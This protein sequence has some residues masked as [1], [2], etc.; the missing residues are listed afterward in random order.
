MVHHLQAAVPSK[1]KARSSRCY[2]LSPIK[3][4]ALWVVV[5]LFSLMS[6]F[7]QGESGVMFP[8]RFGLLYQKKMGVDVGF[9]AFNHWNDQGS[10]L[11]FY[12]VSLGSEAFF[13]KPFMMAPK[14]SFDF[15][16]GEIISFGGGVDVA[17]L[18]DFQQAVWMW[19]PKV[20]VSLGSMLRLYY[21]RS[22]FNPPPGFADLGKH[23]VSL[24]LNIAAFHNFSIGL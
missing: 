2:G 6:A 14:L 1:K 3:L 20:G 17:L 22:I 19:T 10:T 16:M 24:E 5:A 9:V 11:V 23:R 15:G 13:S 18:T 4:R 8:N 12:D 21:G 7:G